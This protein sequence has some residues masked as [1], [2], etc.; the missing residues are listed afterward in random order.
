MIMPSDIDY[1]A[2]KQIMLGRATMNPDFR[3]LSDFINRTFDVKTINII[4]D[5]IDKAN[6]PRLNICFEFEREK[7]SFNEKKGYFIFDREK[8]KIIADKFNIYLDSKANFDNNYQSN[9]YYYYK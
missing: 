8:Q 2:T 4:Y 7:Q 1:K 9:W 5:V 3:E 6:R